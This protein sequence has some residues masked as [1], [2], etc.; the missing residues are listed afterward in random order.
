VFLAL[1]ELVG[2]VEVV[3]EVGVAEE[4]EEVFVVE[5]QVGAFVE[6]GEDVQGGVQLAR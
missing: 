4:L 3:G 6:A 2:G 1:G 5:H